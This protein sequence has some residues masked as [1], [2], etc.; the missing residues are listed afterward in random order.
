VEDAVTGVRAT[1][2]E[3]RRLMV[4]AAHPDDET[5]G[6]GGVLAR[7]AG[8]GVETFLV[9]ATRGE[10]GRYG[11]HRVG[12][13]E[14][15]GPAALARIRARELGEAAA[16][17]GVGHVALLDYEDQQ[18][19][20][21]EV[22]EAVGAIVGWI[23]EAR[24]HVVLTFAPDGAYGHPDHIAVSQFTTAATVAA[25]DPAFGIDRGRQLGPP[26]V[27]S[28]LYYLAWGRAAWTAFEA[29]FKKLVIT[30]DGVERQATPWPDWAV[31][32]VVDTHASSEAVWR[33]VSCHASQT[34]VYAALATL[35]AAEREAL[36][37]SLSFYRAFS[38][39]NG[40][41][42]VE[43]D[44]FEGFARPPRD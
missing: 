21:A 31:T 9:T 27:V 32:T 30:V 23:R 6:F 43:S 33:A 22:I 40:G 8:E 17:L 12:S 14:H 37:G 19:D 41:R 38:L 1:E 26:H 36:F 20:R 24:P 35:T 29:A 11:T 4:V 34:D 7:Y 25:A 15:P 28:K 2:T 39:V 42:A 3:R 16:V 5:L 18:V 13:P 44:L 10:R